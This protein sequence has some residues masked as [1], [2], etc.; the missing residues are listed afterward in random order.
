MTFSSV[1]AAMP[2][3]ER[4][5]KATGSESRRKLTP[6]NT[7]SGP[8]DAAIPAMRFM[9]HTC[10][11][12][13]TMA[14]SASWGVENR[15]T[16]YCASASSANDTSPRVAVQNDPRDPSLLRTAAAYCAALCTRCAGLASGSAAMAVSIIG[17]CSALSRF[18]IATHDSA[19]TTSPSMTSSPARRPPEVGRSFSSAGPS[20]VASHQGAERRG[21]AASTWPTL[22]A[23]RQ[24]SS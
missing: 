18:P 5:R 11:T 17:T 2:E 1:A 9:P 22:R 20:A 4:P 6:M 13:V 12:S 16:G 15:S 23:R 3:E 8:E 24:V 10:R 14:S 7:G 19:V 21:E